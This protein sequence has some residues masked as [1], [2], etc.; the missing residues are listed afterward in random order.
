MIRD[1]RFQDVPELVTM[2]RE[3]QAASKYAGRVEVV[4]KVAES[5]F[6]GLIAGQR[7][8]GPQA[9][10]CAIAEQDSRTVGFMAG[11]LDRVYHVGDKLVAND[12][13]LY[14]RP[15]APLQA[16]KLVDAYLAWASGNPRVV[17]IKLSWTDALPGA[18]RVELIFLRK[19]FNRS[20]GIFELRCDAPAPAPEREMEAA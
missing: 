6:M 12:V 20:G 16:R 11:V 13:Y 5:L 14:V 15:G 3:M 4:D 18:E 10:F 8:S 1:A 2:L 19:G 7:Q 9:G 17:E